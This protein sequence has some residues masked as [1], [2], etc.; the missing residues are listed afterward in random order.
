MTPMHVLLILFADADNFQ[1]RADISILDIFSE[2]TVYLRPRPNM[3]IGALKLQKREHDVN[4][5][6]LA[7]SYHGA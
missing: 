2:Y 6:V 5:I 3:M 4:Q 7:K 1:I